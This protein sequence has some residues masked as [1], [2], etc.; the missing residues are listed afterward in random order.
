MKPSLRRV[1]VEVPAVHQAATVAF[2]AAVLGATPRDSDDDEVEL[3]GVP[4]TL[5]L[6]I[7]VR[8]G[9]PAGYRLDLA[10]D[11]PA[12]AV[13]ALVAAG[14]HLLDEGPHGC[15]S[16]SAGR[17]ATSPSSP[18]RPTVPVSNWR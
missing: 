7:A 15:D 3:V 8:D 6:R 18:P 4:G 16:R 12:A 5:G 13:A 9:V 2:W 14:A 10:A 17:T 11:H 1:R